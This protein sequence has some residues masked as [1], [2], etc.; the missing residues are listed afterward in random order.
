MND[1]P[2]IFIEKWLPTLLRQLAMW[3]HGSGMHSM[4]PVDEPVLST[5]ELIGVAHCESCVMQ[6]F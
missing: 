2:I 5:V 4:A 1:Q 3:D 6:V